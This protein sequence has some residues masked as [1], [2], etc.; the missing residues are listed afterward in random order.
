MYDEQWEY[1]W[2]WV[3]GSERKQVMSF[4]EYGN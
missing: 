3:F 1:E 2:A 4:C